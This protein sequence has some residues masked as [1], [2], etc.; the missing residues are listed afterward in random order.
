MVSPMEVSSDTPTFNLLVITS[1]TKSKVI[2]PDCPAGDILTSHDLWDGR[3]DSRAARH[4]GE[5]ERYRRPAGQLY[6]GTQHQEIMRGVELLRNVFG[7][8]AVEVKIISAGFGLVD[9]HQPIPP[10][11]ATFAGVGSSK[12][13]TISKR[14]S[15][16]S[17]VSAL[18]AGSYSCAFFLLG[19][20]YLRSLGLPYPDTPV[21]PCFFLVSPTNQKYVPQ[22]A[23]YH[24]IQ[25]DESDV[26]AFGCGMIGIKGHLFY[27]FARQIVSQGSPND[28]PLDD[29]VL[30][31][32]RERLGQLIQN[33]SSANLIFRK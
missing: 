17:S 9:E 26:R 11:E 31:S 20:G 13:K 15:I 2:A 18:L 30:A 1:C 10:Y 25:V 5:L 16:P 32:A 14:L 3:E 7:H 24:R 4:Y 6:R 22:G 29:T 21:F 28:A 19:E 8:H 33:P 27:L 23:A 12:I